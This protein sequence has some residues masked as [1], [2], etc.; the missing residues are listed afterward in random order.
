M[1][2]ESRFDMIDD[3]DHTALVCVDEPDTQISIVEQLDAQGYKL[4]TGIFAEDVTLK[5]SA[6]RY[7]VLV[8]SDSFGG[9]DIESNPVIN[10]VRRLPI[11]D[12]RETFVVVIGPDFATNDGMQAFR[13][14]VDM[15]CA[16]S[17]I[18]SFGP[19]LRRAMERH[20]SF[21]AGFKRC[22]E[23]VTAI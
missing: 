8:V 4:H 10:E 9:S 18:L 19:V 12:R 22:V 1:Q 14:S 13:L 17:D 7:D 21:Y 6:Q 5:L 16:I 23:M 15:V 3:G 2:F 20:Q 11:R